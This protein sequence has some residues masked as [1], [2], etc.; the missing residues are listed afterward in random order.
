V[1]L[2]VPLVCPGLAVHVVGLR[3]GCRRGRAGLVG[4]VG[5]L[6]VL[7][8]GGAVLG[9][10]HLAAVLAAVGGS[11]ASVI[12]RKIGSEERAVVL[13]LYQ[14]LANF[15]VMGGALPFVYQPIALVDLGV[16]AAV[17]AFA[18]TATFCIIAA[19]RRAPALVVAPMQYS[20]IVWATVLG[21]LVFGERL[22]LWTVVGAAIVIGSG[23][24]I[25]LR[26]GRSD[27]SENRPVL[28]TRARPETGTYPRVRP[29]GGLP[30]RSAAPR[31]DPHTGD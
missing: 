23:L 22:D 13:M 5:G 21:A 11:V 7:G 12:V 3:V 6:V 16:L 26:E 4:W 31:G 1:L 17:A 15:L 24:Y 30:G 28:Q 27:A 18:F 19:Y 2:S 8:P 14:M 25:L 9:L 10:G 29:L 20:Q